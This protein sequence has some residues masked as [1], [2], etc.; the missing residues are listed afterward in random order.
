MFQSAFCVYAL[1]TY[2][3]I[4]EKENELLQSQQLLSALK[5]NVSKVLLKET[6][7]KRQFCFFIVTLFFHQKSSGLKLIFFF[8]LTLKLLSTS[9]ELKSVFY[10]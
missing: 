9:K 1:S 6:S 3:E 7:E 2:D 4:E 8:F 10:I 5:S